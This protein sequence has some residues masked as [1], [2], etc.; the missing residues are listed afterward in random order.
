LF[1]YSSTDFLVRIAAHAFSLQRQLCTATPAFPFVLQYTIFKTAVYQLLTA[2]PTF[3]MQHQ[4]MNFSIACA[5][6]DQLSFLQHQA[7]N[8]V[9]CTAQAFSLRP[10][11]SIET[12]FF[13]F[14]SSL[15]MEVQ[16]FV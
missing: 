7:F 11:F 10:C 12:I 1:Q 14:S 2:V 15:S 13:H 9:L 4:L 3:V 6:Q 8:C 16:T 5:S